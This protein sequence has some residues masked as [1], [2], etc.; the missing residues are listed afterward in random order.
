MRMDIYAVFMTFHSTAVRYVAEEKTMAV[1]PLTLQDNSKL[2][3]SI[4][5]PGISH[6]HFHSLVCL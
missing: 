4:D 3:F 1:S 6:K 5:L 2:H